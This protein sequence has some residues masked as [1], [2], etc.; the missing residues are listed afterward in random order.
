M[1]TSRTLQSA[2]GQFGLFAIIESR[3]VVL[4]LKG[5]EC[6]FR[7]RG[8]V[9][10][11]CLSQIFRQEN[12]QALDCDYLFPLPADS[13]VYFCE[14]DINGRLIRAEARERSEARQL[15]A[16]KKAEGFRTALVESER[17][18]LFTLN[19]GNVQ[20]DDLVI[21]R[22]KYFQTLRSLD[23]LRSVEIPFCPGVRYIPGKPLLRSNRG[24]GI[25]DDT[26]A[27]PDASRIS[28][29][30]IDAWHP[31]ASYVDVQGSIDAEYAEAQSLVSA[32]HA[33]EVKS[34]D[35]DL[36]VTL[37]NKGEVPDRDFVLRWKERNAGAVAPRAWTCKHRTEIYSLLEIRAPK[38]TSARR[39][40]LDFYFL[41]DRSGSMAGM[42]W[43]K[44][45]EALQNCVR[46][47]GPDDRA[48]ITLFE[49]RFHDFA[50]GPL[51][52]GELIEDPNFQSLPRMGTGGGT[53]MAPAL[54]HVLEVAEAKSQG[55]ER[56]LILITD[57]Q[58]GN[59]SAILD[60]MKEAPGMAVHCFGIDIA[61]ND[62]LLL[63][64]T[65]QQG[66]TFHSLNPNDDIQAAVSALGN[67]LRQP[68]LLDLRL[69][70]GWESADAK[71][72][73]L[74]SGQILYLSARA[75]G[76]TPLKLTARTPAGEPVSFDFQR[77]ASVQEAPYLHWCRTRIHR[78]VAER[79]NQDAIKLS[80]A[81]NLLCQL[82]AFVA[83]DE[84]EKVI[85]A[86]HDLIQPN[87][88]LEERLRSSAGLRGPGPMAAQV[89]GFCQS[90]LQDLRISRFRS[91]RDQ[92]A[93]LS[94][95]GSIVDHLWPVCLRLGIADLLP[96]E[97]A[98]A[99]WLGH[100]SP[101]EIQTRQ[102]VLMRIIEAL[103]ICAELKEVLEKGN[104]AR[105]K[106]LVGQLPRSQRL[107][108][109][110]RNRGDAVAP[111]FRGLERLIQS[112][113]RVGAS[114]PEAELTALIAEVQRHAA[115]TLKRFVESL[116]V[117]K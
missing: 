90:A 17:D 108:S 98:I 1:P 7:V 30:R 43:L 12:P 52:A 68:V 33:I 107:Y 36:R 2:T 103:E 54:R 70:E 64:L 61:L 82:T 93:G 19:L 32:S 31:D 53:E 111:E 75:A 67:T 116:P 80:V 16:Q 20:P 72:P 22:V 26:D 6:E 84:S 101:D 44:A 57:A 37:S 66:G 48:M 8:G 50:E 23:E 89:A 100:G 63:A 29:V 39:T 74:Y 40:A 49:N 85:V 83:W 81:S 115:E 35:G 3:R 92:D 46:M 77:H 15:A 86:R 11:V 58:I 96:P 56:N 24:K 117:Q 41:V 113:L 94:S 28:P 42:K 71:L 9:A 114:C 106:R 97:E 69:S 51:P 91:S 34:A 4:P 87:M 14:A 79:Q 60:L 5:V 95:P 88:A 76:D 110:I 38:Q 45:V 47:L 13:A 112:V 105:D 78:L 65:R 21:I 73:N 18:N 109:Q 62:A 25:A 104:T 10:E 59:E 55:R 102:G 99:E 27:V